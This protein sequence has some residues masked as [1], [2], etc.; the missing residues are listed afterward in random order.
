MCGT[1]RVDC[2][3]LYRCNKWNTLYDDRLTVYQ[4]LGQHTEN[5]PKINTCWQNILSD[6]S[7]NLHLLDEPISNLVL[8]YDKKVLKDKIAFQNQTPLLIE[9]VPFF[10]SMLLSLY[11]PW[12]AETKGANSF[13]AIWHYPHMAYFIFHS[14]KNYLFVDAVTRWCFEICAIRKATSPVYEKM[15][16]KHFV[17]G[18]KSTH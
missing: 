1:T 10:H 12:F 17:I 15:H 7:T 18:T 3:D 9:I 14:P 2:I 4:R 13:Q 5:K 6:T 16:L 11:V 8:F